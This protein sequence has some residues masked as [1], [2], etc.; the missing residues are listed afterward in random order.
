LNP[1][2]WAFVMRPELWFE[3][4]AVWPCRYL[5]HRC[6][7][8]GGSNPVVINDNVNVN[9]RDAMR[10]GM[11]IDVN[12]RKYPVIV[13]DG[14]FEHTNINNASVA[15]GSYASSIYI[16][17]LRVRG[18]FPTTYWEYIDYRNVDTQISPMGAGARQVP[19][20]TDNGRFLW[21]Y[22]DNG[23]CFDLQSLIEPRMIMRTPQ[24]AGK[25]QNVL[26]SPLQ[27]LASPY[28][29]SPYHQDGGV[30]LRGTSTTYNVWGNFQT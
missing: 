13:D 23:Y 22:R 5:T 11:Y 24:L 9:M 14:I 21:V 2:T 4:S 20:W 3:L 29:D 25:L 8:T 1:V 19:F 16:V 26:Y 27:H 15:A 28:P 17:P 12:G 6:A 7:N 10:N 30:S 18:N